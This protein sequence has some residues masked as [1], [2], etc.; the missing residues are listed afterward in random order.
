[1]SKDFISLQDFS[2]TLEFFAKCIDRFGDELNGTECFTQF[3]SWSAEIRSVSRRMTNFTK[4][5]FNPE[6]NEEDFKK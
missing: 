3:E 1:M 5:N 4:E 6:L 2:E